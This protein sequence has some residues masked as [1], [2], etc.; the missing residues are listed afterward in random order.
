MIKKLA[1]SLFALLSLCLHPVFAQFEMNTNGGTYQLVT[2]I[3]KIDDDGV[4]LIACNRTGNTHT[5][6]IMGSCFD[7]NNT[8]LP[9]PLTYSYTGENYVP[10]TI[11]L[12]YVNDGVAQQS[13]STC[14]YEYRIK[15]YNDGYVLQN[16]EE[17]YVSNLIDAK[18]STINNN[19]K[20]SSTIETRCVWKLDFNNTMNRVTFVYTVNKTDYAL[21]ISTSAGNNR[22]LCRLKENTLRPNIYKKIS[23]TQKIT[24]GATGYS[25]L[26]Y[27][28]FDVTLPEGLV[29]FTFSQDAQDNLVV[30]HTYRAGEKIPQNTGVVIKGEKGDYTLTLSIPD[31]SLPTY[32]NLLGGYDVATAIPEDDNSRFYMLSLNSS[33]TPGSVGFYWGSNDGAAFTSGAHKAYLRLPKGSVS[34]AKGAFV[35]ADMDEITG[36]IGI[37]NMARE[38]KEIIYD[39]MGRKVHNVSRGVFIQGGRKVVVH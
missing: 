31:E 3:D 8:I 9:Y 6:Y 18:S 39:V 27:G 4:Y 12:D 34:S 21:G 24:I 10:E 32:D 22:F 13:E 1:Y 33:K 14:A 15:K 38:N 30:S 16:I 26:Y 19:L 28:T 35:L 29:A 17:K 7:E 23:T 20:L 37:R 5:L 25:T 2:S 11:N 36:I